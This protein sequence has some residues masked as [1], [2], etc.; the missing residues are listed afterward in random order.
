MALVDDMSKN[1]FSSA[2]ALSILGC[3]LAT[4]AAFAATNQIQYLSGTDKDHTVPWDFR[5]SAGRNSGFWTNIPVPSCWD[6]KG[7]GSYEYG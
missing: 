3:W 7:F 4:H 1:R 2:F 6:T 5:V